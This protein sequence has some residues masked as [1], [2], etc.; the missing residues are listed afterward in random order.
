MSD[1]RTDDLSDVH[2]Q[3]IGALRQKRPS[4][5]GGWLSPEAARAF[6]S[7]NG[8]VTWLGLKLATLMAMSDWTYTNSDVSDFNWSPTQSRLETLKIKAAMQQSILWWYIFGGG[9][10]ERVVDVRGFK[11]G[12]AP[13]SEPIEPGSIRRVRKLIAWSAYDLE[14]EHGHTYL[15]TPRFRLRDGTHQTFIHRS[16][17]T[18]VVGSDVPPGLGRWS[19]RG[20][21]N[22]QTGWPPSPLEG[23][24]RSRVDWTNGENDASNMLHVMSIVH[25]ALDGYRKARNGPSEDER[26][27]ISAMLQDIVDNLA[28]GVLFTDTGDKVASID[29]AI[30]GLRDLIESKRLTFLS[31]TGFTEEMVLGTAAGNLGENSGG[32]R[33][34]NTLISGL[35]DVMLTPVIEAVTDAVNEERRYQASLPPTSESLDIP[36]EYT[37]KWG[38]IDEPTEAERATTRKDE[39]AARK[40]DA[41]TGLPQEVIATDQALAR[42]YAGYSAWIAEQEERRRTAAVAEASAPPTLEGL[43]SASAVAEKLGISSTKLLGMQAEG[44]I[45]GVKIG[46]RWKFHYPTVWRAIQEANASPQSVGEDRSDSSLGLSPRDHFGECWG[47]SVAMRE[48]FAALEVVAPSDLP[49]LLTGETGTGKELVARGLHQGYGRGDM[50]AI[51]CAMLTDPEAVDEHLARAVTG[52][53]TL[54]LDEVGE[55]SARAQAATLRALAATERRLV[56]ATW[57]DVDDADRFRVDLLHRLAG[58]RVEIPPLRERD[59][60]VLELA[61][62]FAESAAKDAGL[63]SPSP[64]LDPS[65]V[66]ALRRHRWP[67]NVR[68]LSNAIRRA[69]LFSASRRPISAADLGLG[70][71]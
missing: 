24:Y 11:D 46:S 36:T 67:G 53:G 6:Y 45:E 34:R 49:V 12:E 2:E 50:V 60:D 70:D 37:T 19:T 68:E 3:L 63:E 32:R 54:F 66:R 10:I 23:L 64:A 57:R 61:K 69:A 38:A 13:R 14:P 29:R 27:A 47:A 62:R 35:R 33:D 7:Q 1:L 16:R 9:G 41:D 51:N 18:L 30:T 4:V 40:A 20:F 58:I 44:L 17:L 42:D 71:V 39:A 31:D 21:I 26:A 25:I 55:L 22:S 56:A 59:D 52:A 43:E 15:T 48:I 5:Y 28:D 65:A 8:V